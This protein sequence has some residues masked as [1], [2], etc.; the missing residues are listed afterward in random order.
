M[1]MVEPF[2][3]PI[4]KTLCGKLEGVV[5]TLLLLMNL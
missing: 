2:Q 1:P 3:D 4:S 5:Y